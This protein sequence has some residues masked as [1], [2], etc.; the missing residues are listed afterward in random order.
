[1]FILI[2]GVP[3]SGKTTVA[4]ELSKMIGCKSLSV[5]DVV[6]K[7]K[8]YVD[9]EK[10]ECGKPL[11]VVDM[12]KLEELIKGLEGCYIIEGVVVDFVPPEATKKVLYLQARPKTL[13]ARMEQ[14]GYCKEKICSNLEA[15]LVGSYL[16]MLRGLYG[17]KVVCVQSDGPLDRTLEEALKAVKCERLPCARWSQEDF[18]EFSSYC[19]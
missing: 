18:E 10:D 4:K 12:D 19:L 13:I 6:V 16:Q 3:G 1:M 8:L 9:V 5:T 2:A 14:K 11:Y 7:N 15:E 17:D